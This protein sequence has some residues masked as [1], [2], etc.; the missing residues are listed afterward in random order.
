MSMGNLKASIADLLHLQRWLPAPI[1]ERLRL[2][3]KWLQEQQDTFVDIA[4]ELRIW[5]FYETIDSQLSGSRRAGMTSE[6]QFGA[7][8]VSIKSSILG[9]RQE[10]VYSVD[11][12][13]AHCASF[14]EHNLNTMAA[15][16]DNLS[17]AVR[18]ARELSD[19]YVHTPLRLKDHVRVQLIGFY[20]DPD[21]GVDV[22]LYYTKSHLSEFLV[23]G[24]EKC[25]EERLKK[26][27]RPAGRGPLRLNTSPERHSGRNIPQQL[28]GMLTHIPFWNS[29]ATHPQTEDE[30]DPSPG[31]LVT[32][33]SSRP[34]IVGSRLGPVA[35]SGPVHSLT[36]PGLATPGFERPSSRHSDGTASTMSEPTST[37][38]HGS[39]EDQRAHSDDELPPLAGHDTRDFD[40]PFRRRTERTHRLSRNAA[41]QELSAGFSR[42][43]PSLRKF[44]WIH[45]PFNNPLWV[46]VRKLLP[47]VLRQP[48]SRG[49][50]HELTLGNRTYL[51][52]SPE[53]TTRTF[54]NCL[55]MRTGCR[56]TYRAA[57][58]SR[59]R[60]LSSLPATTYRPSRPRP[61]L[62]ETRGATADRPTDPARVTCTCISRTST[63][64]RTGA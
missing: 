45:L 33:P 15:F 53:H 13:H 35:P 46:K 14:G 58:L 41:F 38:E 47:D 59:S 39:L 60:R 37:L 48:E 56:D 12:D 5:T 16:L 31:I 22:R 40:S 52:C 43:N 44:I 54:R 21:A 23:K 63:S 2:G 3:D 64:I 6:V 34:S 50:C 61:L 30:P 62:L 8:L 29:A 20:D 25:L 49:K 18:K 36:V 42:P 19:L 28:Q 55:T 24:P 7:P 32:E 4:S 1:A 11:S 26:M 17:K 9:V 27:G 51:R 57:T 10:N